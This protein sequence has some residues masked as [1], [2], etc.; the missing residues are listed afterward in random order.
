MVLVDVRSKN[1]IN[2]TRTGRSSK[3]TDARVKL[4]EDAYFSYEVGE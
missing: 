2:M 1:G 3:V 4:S